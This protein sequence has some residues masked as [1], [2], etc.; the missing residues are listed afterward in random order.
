MEKILTAVAVFSLLLIFAGCS[1][2]ENSSGTKSVHISV[3]EVKKSGAKAD[4]TSMEELSESIANLGNDPFFSNFNKLFSYAANNE[5]NVYLASYSSRISHNETE[6]MNF[7]KKDILGEEL[8]GKLEQFGSDINKNGRASIN[9]SRKENVLFKAKGI[10]L[11]DYVFSLKGKLDNINRTSEGDVKFKVNMS[12]DPAE[13]AEDSNI[14]DF[15]FKVVANGSYDVK[16]PEKNDKLEGNIGVYVSF[17]A[18]VSFVDP[19][20]GRGGILTVS[21]S[22]NPDDRIE[23]FVKLFSSERKSKEVVEK[24]FKLIKPV[25]IIDMKNDDGVS[26]FRR[27]CRKYSDFE[28]FGNELNKM[29]EKIKYS[30]N[31]DYDSDNVY[32][33]DDDFPDDA[34]LTLPDYDL[35]E[36]SENFSG[37]EAY[38]SEYGYDL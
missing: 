37:P 6:F 2:D 9:Y 7:L 21:F 32:D 18:A 15:I 12:V 17:A 11:K 28:E 4:I 31:E 35:S 30:S 1:K 34:E 27:E 29:K 8:V 23:K 14:K 13:I 24:S 33:M 38:M 26:T 10:E 22:L 3:S 16:N 36:S 5:K 20:T 25:F 19:K